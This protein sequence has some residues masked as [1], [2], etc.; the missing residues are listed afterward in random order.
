M[1]WRQLCWGDNATGWD[2]YCAAVE[3][4]SKGETQRYSAHFAADISGC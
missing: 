1:G 3:T 2:D 4:L